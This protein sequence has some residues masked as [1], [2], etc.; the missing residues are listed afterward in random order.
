MSMACPRLLANALL[1]TGLLVGAACSDESDGGRA[2]PS[3]AASSASGVVTAGGSVDGGPSSDPPQGDAA[4][5]PGPDVPPELSASD[6]SVADDL[7]AKGI[8]GEQLETCVRLRTAANKVSRAA[9]VGDFTEDLAGTLRDAGEG[10]GGDVSEAMGALAEAY[11]SW[12]RDGASADFPGDRLAWAS[13]TLTRYDVEH[14]R[15]DS[16]G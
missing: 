8:N 1:T 5:Q 11:E 14:C 6:E 10:L 3:P 13:E 15:A 7:R 2:A 16:G 12:Q 9:T 4:Q